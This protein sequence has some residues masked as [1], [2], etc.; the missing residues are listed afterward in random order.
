MEKLNILVLGYNRSMGHGM[1]KWG[2]ME[3][4]L[5][6]LSVDVSRFARGKGSFGQIS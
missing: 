3:V 5:L 1:Y 2:F 4:L 6:F